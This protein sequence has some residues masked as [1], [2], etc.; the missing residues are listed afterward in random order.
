[1][2]KTNKVPAKM[3]KATKNQSLESFRTQ[4]FGNNN[5]AKIGVLKTPL[6]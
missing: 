1:M 4:I 3:F 6:A 2:P 5:K